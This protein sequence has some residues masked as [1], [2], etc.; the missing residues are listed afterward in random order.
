ML[1]QNELGQVYPVAYVAKNFESNLD[2]VYVDIYDPSYSHV[3]SFSMQEQVPGVYVYD[4]QTELTDQSGFYYFVTDSK[5][6]TKRH[7]HRVKFLISGSGSYVI[8]AF[9]DNL[10]AGGQT[11]HPGIN[12]FD[13][14]GVLTNATLVE[15]DSIERVS[16]GQDVTSTF[17]YAIN[18]TSTG[19]YEADLSVPSDV[20]SGFYR[21]T[22]RVTMGTR[23]LVY[24]V[25]VNVFDEGTGTPVEPTVPSTMIYGYVYSANGVPAEGVEVRVRILDAR[26]PSD[27]NIIITDH[28]LTTY[29]DDDGKFTFQTYRNV[30]FELYV[31]DADF[32]GRGKTL[33]GDSTPIAD[34]ILPNLI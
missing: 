17:D 16:D 22:W 11:V 18:H 3:G 10:W 7:V 13:Q 6:F 15:I 33:S 23:V 4:F 25:T 29:T 9:G 1:D 5:S 27:Q 2:D 12:V 20:E 14:F 8:G 19:A 21:L 24:Q 28:E 26:V 30:N 31:D 32:A 34:I